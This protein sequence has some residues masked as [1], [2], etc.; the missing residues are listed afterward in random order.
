MRTPTL[1]ESQLTG[2]G[3][4]QPKRVL[5]NE[6]LA[7]SVDTSDEWIRTRTGIRERHIAGPDET[8]AYMATE[9]ARMALA[10][11]GLD[12]VSLVVVASTTL[13]DR[14]P[15]T[16]ARV[17]ANLGMPGPAV[18]DINTAC[19]GF[20]HA[21]AIADQA[22]SAGTADSAL[23]IGAER[24]S[25]V[26]DWTDRRTCILTADGAG[27]AVLTASEEPEISPVVWGSVPGMTDAVVIDGDPQVFSQDGQS[28]MRWA[29][30]KAAP[31]VRRALETA[32]VTIDD[33]DVIAFHQAN[34]RLIEPL[35][36]AIGATERHIVI[37]DIEESG[38]TSA[39]SVPLGL[40]KAWHRGE[41]PRGGLALLF[42]FGGGFAFAGQVVRLPR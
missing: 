4:Y 34:L 20:E 24:L 8:V 22:I 2:L 1:R 30:T 17:A 31:H 5:T 15:F 33:I 16:A 42:G 36:K 41:L 37:H 13:V 39:A 25:D 40:S 27:A 21:V 35:A 9:A 28:I 19:S 12:T 11:A 3:H 18:I 23:V 10:D 14:T 32:G 38:N 7:R 26:T 29:L 6:E